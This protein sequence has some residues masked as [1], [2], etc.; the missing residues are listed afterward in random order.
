MSHWVAVFQK[1]LKRVVAAHAS[2]Q[3]HEEVLHQS[4]VVSIYQYVRQCL[5]QIAERSDATEYQRCIYTNLR[6]SS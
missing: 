1:L 6:R 2:D 5:V 4:R 3:S